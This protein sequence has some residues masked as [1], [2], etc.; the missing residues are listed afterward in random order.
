MIEETLREIGIAVDVSK[1]MAMES[2]M[3]K[4]RQG[5]KK[6]RD[7]IVAEERRRDETKRGRRPRE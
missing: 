6:C 2:E 7:E 3:S 4:T 5:K 1:S